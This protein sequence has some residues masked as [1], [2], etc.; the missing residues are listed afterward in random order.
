MLI[1]GTEVELKFNH[2]FYKNIVKGYKDKD[3]YGF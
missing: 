2:R 1:K 3:N